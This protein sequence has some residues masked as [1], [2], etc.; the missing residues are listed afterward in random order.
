VATP[1]QT[2]FNNVTSM[3]ISYTWE[4][5]LNENQGGGVCTGLTKEAQYIKRTKT[6]D[7]EVTN[8][9]IDNSS[10][11]VI[12]HYASL[13]DQYKN[14]SPTSVYANGEFAGRGK[15]K[16]Y[17]INAGSQSNLTQTSLTYEMVDGGP[18]K[19]DSVDEKEDPVSIEET[20]KVS[21]DVR[22]KKYSIVHDF[23]ISFGDDFEAVTNFPPYAVDNRYESVDGRLTLGAEKAQTALSANVDYG[24]FIDLSAYQTE[25]GWN[26]TKINDDCAGYFSS[27]SITRDYINGDYSESKTIEIRYT[28]TDVEQTP[29]IYE[30]NYSMDFSEQE[31]R[32]EKIDHTVCSKATM[33]G[34]IV[35]NATSG[36]GMTAAE[37]AAFGYQDFVQGGKAEAILSGFFNSLVNTIDGIPANPVNAGITNLKKES[38]KDGAIVNFQGEQEQ[39]SASE[40]S[41]SISFSF[42]MDNCP[43]RQ[44][45]TA[46]EPPYNF[47]QTVTQS[48]SFN[49]GCD[50]TERKV[51]N[52]TVNGS[53]QG[54][55]GQQVDSTGGY[56]RWSNVSTIFTTKAS[57]AQTKAESEYAGDFPNDFKLK[58]KS[59][60][61]DEYNANGSF[62]V[63]YDDS[64]LSCGE[65][66][67]CFLKEININ[68]TAAKERKAE[69]VT[70][71]GIVVE[72][73]NTY[74]PARKSADVSLKSALE[75][76]D[77]NPCPQD[78]ESFL[79][80]L[81]TELNAEAPS[82][83]IDKLSWSFSKSYDNPAQG[84]GQVEGINT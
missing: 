51:T 49:K 17:S 83:L 79:A 5:G 6:V 35:G 74:N 30:V 29:D 40:N 1:S 57:A 2:D 18:D 63:S 47:N 77:G 48:Y 81:K 59:E 72:K 32:V 78:L 62:S 16:Q 21:R 31:K 80:K 84:K 13:Q 82:C 45:K 10:N 20:I 25:A 34:T 9:D 69:T 19:P 76:A 64:S 3:G 38:C 11:E 71:K 44:Q 22:G 33:Q 7:L 68:E 24:S 27:T 56:P 14:K 26:F 15:L 70:A 37:A 73:K 43:D 36:C 52:I 66:D 12:S 60:T 67:G 42:D 28:G 53:V 61:I 58:S 54:V 75:D 8:L 50:G 39:I 41:N 4:H 65:L 46:T 23:S 55:C